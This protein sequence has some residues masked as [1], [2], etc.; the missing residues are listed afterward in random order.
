MV[1]TYYEQTGG[2]GTL[3]FHAGRDYV[4]RA[5]WARSAELF[6]S[7]VAP[8]LRHLDPDAEPSARPAVAA[9]A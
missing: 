6:M 5:Q 2:F 1:K 7:E 4:S 3:L 8:Q 9:V